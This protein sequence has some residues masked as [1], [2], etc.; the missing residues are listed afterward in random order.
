VAGAPVS[1]DR[2]IN[3]GAIGPNSASAV[4]KRLL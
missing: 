3:R 4:K 2:C 1:T